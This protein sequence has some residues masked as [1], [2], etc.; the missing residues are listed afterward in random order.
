MER[1]LTKLQRETLALERFFPHYMR[2]K[3]EEFLFGF[4]VLFISLS[5]LFNVEAH[6]RFGM[7]WPI[8][9]GLFL[10]CFALLLIT[11]LIEAYSYSLYVRLQEEDE[12][13]FGTLLVIALHHPKKKDLAK[14]FLH[15]RLGKETMKKLGIAKET[16]EAFLHSKEHVDMPIPQKGMFKDLAKHIHDE[17]EYVRSF[18]ERSHVSRESLVRASA[19]VEKKHQHK[20]HARVLLSPVFKKHSE[21]KLTIEEATYEEIEELESFYRI[22]ITEQA[23]HA[24]V[25]Y[26]RKDLVRYAVS[27]ERIDFMNGLIEHTL[28]S[29][30]ERFHGSSVVLPSDVRQYIIHEKNN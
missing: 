28:A 7:L 20:A 8:C 24:M 19:V 17:D 9:Q 12:I 2:E 13:S 1:S 23:S 6:T 29:H 26:F 25:D 15:S 21:P 30:G 16:L 27:D 11:I 5:V 4:S 22:I 10:I 14:A 3:A 18:F